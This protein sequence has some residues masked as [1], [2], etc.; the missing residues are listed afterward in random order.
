MPDALYRT[1]FAAICLSIAP[2]AQSQSFDVASIKPAAIWKAGGEG[3]GSRS[4]IEVTADTLTMLNIDLNEMVQW[5]YTLQPF[6][7]SDRNLLRD[8]RYDVRARSSEP[9]SLTQMRSMLQDLLATRFKLTAHREPKRTSVF[10]LVIAKGGPKLPPNKTGQLPSSY[11][12][13]NLPRVV[14][15]GFLFTN[16]TLTEFAEQ[17][18]QLRPIGQPVLDRTGISGVYDITLKLTARAMLQEDGPSLFTLIEEQLGLK[19]VAAKDETPML[20][21][22][23]AEEPSQ[24]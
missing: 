16:T 9:V 1:V 3:S 22:D 19:L 20:I 4:R 5:A 13:E 12:R 2:F 7:I 14:D 24:N 15:G 17:L 8:N 10:E 23:H 6:Q 18:S 11:P 21:V